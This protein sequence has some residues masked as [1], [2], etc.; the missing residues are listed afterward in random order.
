VVDVGVAQDDRMEVEPVEGDLAVAHGR[1]FT[2]SLE[3][4]AIEQD[5]VAVHFDEMLASGDALSGSVA[6]D[7]HAAE[8]RVVPPVAD[9]P[10][11]AAPHFL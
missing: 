9:A 3:N 8:P 5:A 4:A 11:A 6:G 10:V 7:A 1:F 2:S